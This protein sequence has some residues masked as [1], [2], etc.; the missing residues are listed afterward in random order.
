MDNAIK[1]ANERQTHITQ[2]EESRRTYW[3]R[4]MAEHDRVSGLRAYPGIR[5]GWMGMICRQIMT[6]QAKCSK[7]K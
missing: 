3:S 1:A 7:A 4:R 6:A 5:P 2:D